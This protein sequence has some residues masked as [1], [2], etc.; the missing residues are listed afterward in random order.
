MGCRVGMGNIARPHSTFTSLIHIRK[1]QGKRDRNRK[2]SGGG[3]FHSFLG[4]IL[5]YRV[6]TYRGNRSIGKAEFSPSYRVPGVQSSTAP[7]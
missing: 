4:N 6:L 1:C 5:F 3:G 7:R 2:A